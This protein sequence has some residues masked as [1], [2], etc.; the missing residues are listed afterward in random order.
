MPNQLH[1]V[2]SRIDK[3][4]G[5]APTEER[6][7]PTVPAVNEARILACETLHD[8][9]YGHVPGVQ[10]QMDRI[11]LPTEAEYPRMAAGYH[12]R[13]QLLE[14]LVIL[15]LAEDLLV[16]GAAQCDVVDAARHVNPVSA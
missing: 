10:D 15:R 4:G 8:A 1:Q 2:S 3:P 13:Q 6:A 16:C 9:A 7:V 11:V 5:V 14:N 12:F